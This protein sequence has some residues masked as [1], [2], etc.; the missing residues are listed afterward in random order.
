MGKKNNPLKPQTRNMARISPLPT[1][2]VFMNKN[3][4][5]WSEFC[6]CRLALREKDTG[7]LSSTVILGRMA[8]KKYEDFFMFLF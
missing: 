3:E 4:I 2:F 8:H 6:V 1:R 5:Q 7:L